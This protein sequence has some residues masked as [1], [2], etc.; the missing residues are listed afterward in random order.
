MIFIVPV[1]HV[2]ITPV[3]GINWWRTAINTMAVM[4]M[5]TAVKIET[6]I[7]L[8]ALART[9]T[10]IDIPIIMMIGFIIVPAIRCGNIG[11]SIISP[12]TVEYVPITL[13]GWIINW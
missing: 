3:C 5:V 10:Q 1:E 13:A 2:P 4:F 7:V 12:V 6:T 8:R 9:V 11:Y